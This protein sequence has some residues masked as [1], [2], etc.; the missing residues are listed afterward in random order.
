MDENAVSQPSSEALRRSNSEIQR[1]TSAGSASLPANIE[2]SV[3]GKMSTQ[4][5]FSTEIDGSLN[6]W[7]VHV[8]VARSDDYS[9]LRQCARCQRNGCR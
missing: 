5:N 9:G 6:C 8:G 7:H 1:A 3:K 2:A 4:N